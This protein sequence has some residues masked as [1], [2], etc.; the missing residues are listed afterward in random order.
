MNNKNNKPNE[1][2]NMNISKTKMMIFKII[3]CVIA[4]IIIALTIVYFIDAADK[5]PSYFTKHF[6]ISIILFMC[7][8]IAF[9]LPYVSSKSYRGDK[10]GDKLM[11][12]ISFLLFAF[13]IFQII[14]SYM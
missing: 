12:V 7:A 14:I 6:A 2:K 4:A 9:I 3:F 13:A 10:K 5:E 1:V 8:I 11:I